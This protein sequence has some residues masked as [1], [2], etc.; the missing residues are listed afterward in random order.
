MSGRRENDHDDPP[1][2]DDPLNLA[3]AIIDHRYLVERLAGKGGFGLVYRAT[4]LR[5][6]S[7]VAIKVLRIPPHCEGR[8]RERI[9]ARFANEGKV[10]FN[11]G[12]LHPGIVRVFETGT[13]PDHVAELTP[14]LAMEWL[15][16][17][18]LA[19]LV[20]ERAAPMGLSDTLD[21]LEVAVQGLAAAHAASVAHCDIKPAN[22]FI[23][24]RDA[25]RVTKLVDFGLAE[26][27]TWTVTASRSTANAGGGAFTQAYAAPEQWT[28]QL[29][30]TGPWT[31]VHALALLC[32]ELLSG[33]R[34]FPEN[35]P[36]KL[37]ASC[38]D[39]DRRPTP[40]RLGAPQNVA[41]E[42]VFE[43]ALAVSPRARFCDAGEFWQELRRAA[44]PLTART[45]GGAAA[46]PP[47][48]TDEAPASA[49]TTLPSAST[50]SDDSHGSALPAKMD[51]SRSRAWGKVFTRRWILAAVAFAVV[52]VFGSRRSR[53]DSRASSRVASS[54][55][56]LP[57]RSPGSQAKESSMANQLAASSTTVVAPPQ[58]LPRPI[59]SK[60]SAPR[61][62]AGAVPASVPSVSLE[63]GGVPSAAA[64]IAPTP[65]PVPA[66]S[67][68]SVQPTLDELL[69]AEALRTRR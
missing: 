8:E 62:S 25:R 43:K 30:R 17:A 44:A 63:P 61:A 45:R 56:A 13:L 2:Y 27:V 34:A 59:T 24:S 53:Q 39:D 50:R 35:D 21:L 31:D 28:S 37:M 32:A 16:G 1:G 22:I 38:L 33:R 41:V 15:D 29:G 18:P 68:N 6:E 10:A 58:V 49:P 26:V 14:Y 20:A 47:P 55:R 42:R 48:T 54:A 40:A 65:Q 4:H 36:R 23:C 11:L 7:P 9:V 3:G 19:Q 60:R 57:S 66:T 51:S 52:L 69:N 5:F 46:T 64:S 67:G 12:A